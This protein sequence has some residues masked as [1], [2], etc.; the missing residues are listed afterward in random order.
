MVGRSERNRV[1]A[2]VA[3]LAVAVFVAREIRKPRPAPPSA[4]SQ[5]GARARALAE[6]SATS[7]GAHLTLLESSEDLAARVERSL[8][9]NAKRGANCVG[10]RE[11]CENKYSTAVYE[12][13]ADT[14]DTWTA[15]NR[16]ELWAIG[17]RTSSAPLR[18]A[19]NHSCRGED[20]A[21]EIRC[22]V[23]LRIANSVSSLK[24][25]PLDP[26]VFRNLRDMSVPKAQLLLENFERTRSSPAAIGSVAAVTTMEDVEERVRGAALVS[27][28]VVSPADAEL[29]IRRMLASPESLSDELLGAAIP[30]ALARC[31]AVCSI[32]YQDLA[33]S[34]DVAKRN[35]AFRALRL[36]P[37][38]QN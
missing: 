8:G 33:N 18:D 26:E 21:A 30:Q 23:G 17:K 28:A 25:E 5:P 20:E 16:V 35:V 15:Q 2:A 29:A 9:D 24:L 3:V 19:L 32:L 31:G 27:L 38:F 6:T 34:E 11:A 10:D 22:I 1:L 36:R 7:M 37:G 4:S 12:A 13:L 14:V